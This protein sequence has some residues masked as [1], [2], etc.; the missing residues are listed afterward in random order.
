MAFITRAVTLG[1]QHLEKYLLPSTCQIFPRQAQQ[2]I[3]NTGLPV[4]GAATPK[5]WR[6]VTNIICR[7]EESRAFIPDRLK[8]QVADVNSFTLELPFDAPVE[9]EDVIVFA[10]VRY[11]IAKLSKATDMDVSTVALI[12]EL[13]ANVDVTA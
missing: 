6:S 1:R 4:F 7:K 11:E 2:G 10:G 12:R 3:S 5:T 9:S 8:N 13:S